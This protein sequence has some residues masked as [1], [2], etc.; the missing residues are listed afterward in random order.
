M[1]TMKGFDTRNRR[2]FRITVVGMGLTSLVFLVAALLG[3]FRPS[4]P[5]VLEATMLPLLSAIVCAVCYVAIGRYALSFRFL[6]LAALAF[7]AALYGYGATLA[8]VLLTA[9]VSLIGLIGS[10]VLGERGDT[11]VETD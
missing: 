10:F 5:G 7:S 6:A 9:A 4:S 8:T 2:F 1:K 11:Q 3:K